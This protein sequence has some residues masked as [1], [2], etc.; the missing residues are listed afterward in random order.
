[1][2]KGIIF[3][4]FSDPHL[5]VTSDQNETFKNVG[6]PQCAFLYTYINAYLM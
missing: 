3:F 1:M 2:L 6:K 4:V 5:N